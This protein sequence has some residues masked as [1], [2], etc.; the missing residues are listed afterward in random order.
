MLQNREQESSDIHGGDELQ[1]IY[2]YIINENNITKIMR[3]TNT[4]RIIA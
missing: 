4:V 3:R 2:L 1:S